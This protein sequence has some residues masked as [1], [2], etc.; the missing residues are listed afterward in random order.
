MSLTDADCRSAKAPDKPR[1]L[2][3]EKGLYLLVNAT[4]RYWRMDYRF[5]GKRKT[6]ALG[7][8]PEVSLKAAREGRDAAR[9]LCRDGVDPS[10]AKKAQRASQGGADTFEAVARE[11]YEKHAPGWAET[12]RTKIISRLENDVFPWIGSRPIAAIDPPELLAVARRIE[13]RGTLDTAHRALQNCGQVFRYAVATGRAQRDPSGDLRG[14]LPP[15]RQKDH[16]ATITEP[17]AIGE[18]LRAIDGYAGSFVTRCALKLAPLVF[19][20]PGE[21]RHAEWSEINF[22]AREWRIPPEKMKGRVLH[23]VPLSEQAL[24]I[25]RELQ[26]LTGGGRYV[27]PGEYNR[28]RPMSENTIL[29]GLRRLGYSKE[30]MTGHGFRGMASTLLN[31]QGWKH[32]AIERQLAHAERNKVRAAYNYAE[33]LPERRKMMQAYADYLDSLRENRKII[34]GNF[35]GNGLSHPVAA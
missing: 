16:F 34:A 7:V 5:G 20:R 27:F 26:P 29:A 17:A 11:W 8:Y 22:D 12:H 1:K 13:S 4:G 21:L 25:L 2:S 3:D 18:L 28:S 32:D 9:S 19:V 15:L 35:G 24:A 23:I 6:L 31:E 14:A 10:S 33:H 30:Q